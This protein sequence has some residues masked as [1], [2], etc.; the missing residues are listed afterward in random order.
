MLLKFTIMMC[1]NIQDYYD[2]PLIDLR[3]PVA[4]CVVFCLLFLYASIHDAANENPLIVTHKMTIS[5]KRVSEF[6]GS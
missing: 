4:F 2:V 6:S 3:K 1:I 5:A